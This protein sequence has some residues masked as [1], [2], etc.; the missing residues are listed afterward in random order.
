[1]RFVRFPHLADFSAP[2]PK[3]AAQYDSRRRPR[4]RNSSRWPS[5]H[6]T[7]PQQLKMTLTASYGFCSSSRWPSPHPTFP[8][9][10]KMALAASYVSATAQDP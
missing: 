7:L 4:L 10:L 9:Q 1:M 3:S 2:N 8:P 5:P 6:P